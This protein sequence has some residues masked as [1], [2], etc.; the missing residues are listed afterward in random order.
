MTFGNTTLSIDSY[1]KRVI[2]LDNHNLNLMAQSVRLME[3][4]FVQRMSV[5][6]IYI[7]YV[8]TIEAFYFSMRVGAGSVKK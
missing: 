6:N 5:A 1:M 2:F 3:C 8:L 7:N 4:V